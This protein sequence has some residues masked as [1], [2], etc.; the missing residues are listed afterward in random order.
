MKWKTV[1]KKRKGFIN[2]IADEPSATKTFIDFSFTVFD[3]IYYFRGNTFHFITTCNF[4]SFYKISDKNKQFV[5]SI[6]L[7]SNVKHLLH[8][9]ISN[10]N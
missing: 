9:G 2:T 3:C 8:D 1:E 10:L 5:E 7:L 4:S 6:N